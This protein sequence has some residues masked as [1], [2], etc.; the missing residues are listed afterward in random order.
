MRRL[1]V[2]LLFSCSVALA[3]TTAPAVT[4]PE[5]LSRVDATDPGLRASRA[6]IAQVQHELSASLALPRTEVELEAAHATSVDATGTDSSLTV[7]QPLDLFNRRGARRA[8]GQAQVEIEQASAAQ[9][10]LLTHALVRAAYVE[11]LA[12]TLALQSAEED[13]DAARQI[14]QLVNH[15]ADLGETREVDRLRIQVERQRAEDRVE[16]LQIARTGA[17]RTLRLLVGDAL[18]PIFTLTEPPSVASRSY[19]LV[20]SDVLERNPRV[21][22]ARAG[23]AR[24][25]AL[26]RLANANRLPDP[27]IGAFHSDEIDKKANGVVVGFSLPLFGWNRGEIAAATAA[28][29]RAKAERELASRDVAADF[30]AAWYETEAVQRHAARLKTELLPR[31]RRTLEIADFAYRQGETSQLDYL[32][33]RRT[34]VAIQQES[35]EAMRVLAAAESRLEQITGDAGNAQ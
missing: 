27:S 18:P 13:R 26:L 2:F 24:A 6:A 20:L 21:Q 23:E 32:D 10:R 15:R 31:A 17:E 30:N 4:L 8:A 25:L 3:Q 12:D 16:Q 5:L 14:E 35:L 11:L 19:D 22:V 1:F 7:R 33:A 9:I 29:D 34:Y 28:V